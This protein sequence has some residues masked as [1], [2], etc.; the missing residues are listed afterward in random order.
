MQQFSNRDNDQF[1]GKS[2][3]VDAST[4]I[5]SIQTR[6]L[7]ER[8]FFIFSQL[9]KSI[10]QKEYLLSYVRWWHNVRS[11]RCCRHS[12]RTHHIAGKMEYNDDSHI[13]T[14]GQESN[15]QKYSINMNF[16]LYESTFSMNRHKWN[17]ERIFAF[18]LGQV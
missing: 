6:L 15:L 10:N 11:H 14:L 3:L 17:M 8:L 5:H 2:S 13:K 9:I 18:R 12:D 1:L 7:F 4:N 16:R